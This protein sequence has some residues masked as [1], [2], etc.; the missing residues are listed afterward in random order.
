MMGVGEK[1][2]DGVSPVDIGNEAEGTASAEPQRQ[3][4]VWWTSK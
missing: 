4:C 3:E 1:N 2:G